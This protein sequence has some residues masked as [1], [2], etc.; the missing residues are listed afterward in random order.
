[1]ITKPTVALK[2]GADTEPFSHSLGHYGDSQRPHSITLSARAN[3]VSGI[4]RPRA[5]AVLRL[6]TR[7]KL[8]GCSIG[9]SLAWRREGLS[10]AGAQP[11]DKSG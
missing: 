8:V 6:I 1:M 11:D 7:S 10:Q 2:I 3:S 9:R 4:A 5:L